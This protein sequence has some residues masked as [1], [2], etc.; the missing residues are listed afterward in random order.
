MPSTTHITKPTLPSNIY[1]NSLHGLSTLKNLYT[2]EYYDKDN[3][4]IN[5]NN[6]IGVATKMPSFSRINTVGTLPIEPFS[7]GNNTDLDTKSG[8]ILK[9]RAELDQKLQ[10]LYYT[11]NSLVSEHKVSYDT[12]MYTGILW[13]ILATSVLY[14][15][16]VKL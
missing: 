13:T 10:D 12:T 16:F 2:N 3:K 7:T 8:D 1:S 15:V 5:H 14:Y 11:N 4:L 6:N 9:L